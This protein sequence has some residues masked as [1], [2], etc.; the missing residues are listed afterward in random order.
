M[1]RREFSPINVAALDHRHVGV[2]AAA[3]DQHALRR[4]LRQLDGLIDQRLVQHG[5]AH[6]AAAVGGHHQGGPGIVDARS[7]AGRG[8]TAEHHRVHRADPRAGEDREHRLR[9]VR[10]VDD[11]A[12]ALAYA[13]GHHHRS[14]PLHFGVQ[15]AIGVALFLVDLGGNPH[16]RLLVAAFGQVAVHCVVAEVGFAADEPFCEWRLRVF[17]NLGKRLVPVDPLGFVP[18][19]SFL[20]LDRTAVDFL[21]GCHVSS[22]SL[23]RD[24]TRFWIS[25]GH[26]T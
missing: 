24:L 19:E 20:V 16:Q 12:I 8:E 7:K 22:L 9:R 11:D 26:T 23:N 6:P 18:P 1:L 2:Q 15:L 14:G 4:E 13:E 17:E 10:H 3:E 21:Y 25:S 5:L